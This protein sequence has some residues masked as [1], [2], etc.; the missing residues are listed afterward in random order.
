MTEI[1]RDYE[2]SLWILKVRFENLREL[3][4]C[5]FGSV[6]NEDRN[7]SKILSSIIRSLLSVPVLDKLTLGRCVGYREDAFRDYAH[8]HPRSSSFVKRSQ[9][10]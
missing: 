7:Q 6:P 9:S 10:C 4:L 2:I 1:R 3:H 8:P 5:L